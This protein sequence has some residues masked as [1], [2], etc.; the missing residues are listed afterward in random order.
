MPSLPGINHQRAIKAFEKAGFRIVRQ[1][2]HITMTDGEHIL[3]IPRANPINAYT[4]G[5]IIKGAGMSIEEFK[6]LL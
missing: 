1:G 6:K 4:M 2:K 3:T 5:T